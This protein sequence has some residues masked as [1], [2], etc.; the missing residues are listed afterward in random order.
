M[1]GHT[2]CLRCGSTKLV[3]AHMEQPTALCVDHSAHHG[4]LR[5][6]LKA[7]LCEHCGHVEFWL[8]DPQILT[9]E[10]EHQAA[11]LQEEDF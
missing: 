6:G 8:P 3:A 5:V 4:V 7:A 2:H 11:I 1:I 10:R 9:P